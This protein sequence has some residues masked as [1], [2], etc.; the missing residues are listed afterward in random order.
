MSDR[1]SVCPNYTNSDFVH[2][3]RVNFTGVFLFVCCTLLAGAEAVGNL[4]TS[5]RKTKHLIPF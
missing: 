1:L 2:L 4:T 3:T 5:R